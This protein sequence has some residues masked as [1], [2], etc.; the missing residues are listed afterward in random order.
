MNRMQIHYANLETCATA[1]GVV[2]VIDVIRA[3]T[4]AAYGLAAGAS[5]IV[6]T[7][8][9]EEA[10]THRRNF[11]SARAMGEVN[12]LPAPG[13]DFGNSPSVL[14][15]KNMTGITLIHRTTAGTQGAVRAIR[16]S[17][18]FGACFVVAEA[19]AR[20]LRRLNPE[21][22]TFIITGQSTQDP[23]DEDRSLADYLTALLTRGPV[24]PAP[25]LARVSSAFTAQKFLDPGQPDFPAEDLDCCLQLDRFSFAMPIERREN[26]LVLRAQED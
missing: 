18:L 2:V 22:V 6:L 17:K 11:P 21:S 9:I 14:S 20:S 23:A 15:Q 13:F 1:T 8:T 10:L 16:A 3:F 25:Y 4:T 12:G 7:G 24:D 19:T 5:E 26:M